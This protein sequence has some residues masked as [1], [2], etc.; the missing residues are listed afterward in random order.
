M[1]DLFLRWKMIGRS[2][3]SPR[4]LWYNVIAANTG[5]VL[6]RSGRNKWFGA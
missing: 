3:E 5:I 6:Q 4:P 1:R 2:G